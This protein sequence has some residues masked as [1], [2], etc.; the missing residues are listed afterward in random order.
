MNQKQNLASLLGR[1]MCLQ[2]SHSSCLTLGF[3]LQPG[4][5]LPTKATELRFLLWPTVHVYTD[6]KQEETKANSGQASKDDVQ[7]LIHSAGCHLNTSKDYLTA[8]KP[9]T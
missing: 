2:G 4:F 7:Q 9:I 1:V 5:H 3:L 6:L 8:R